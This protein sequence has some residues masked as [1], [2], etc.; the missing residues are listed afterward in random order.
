MEG[1]RERRVRSVTFYATGLDDL[2]RDPARSR[3]IARFR[4][5][6]GKQVKTYVVTVSELG[7]PLSEAF[8]RLS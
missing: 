2:S 6:H 7:M 5:E 8:P 3:V 4:M 1:L